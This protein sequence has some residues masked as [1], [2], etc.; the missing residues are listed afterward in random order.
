M[1]I[2]QDIV[3]TFSYVAIFTPKYDGKVKNALKKGYSLKKT[4]GSE[5]RAKYNKIMTV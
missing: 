5:P 3:L 2:F 1:L 4:C